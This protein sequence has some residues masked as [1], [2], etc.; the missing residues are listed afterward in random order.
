MAGVVK[1]SVHDLREPLLGWIKGSRLGLGATDAFAWAAMVLDVLRLESLRPAAIQD[2]WLLLVPHFW[3]HDA[4]L[5]IASA[6]EWCLV[7]LVLL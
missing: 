6:R 2:A 1:S 4:A 3:E 5:V 7:A